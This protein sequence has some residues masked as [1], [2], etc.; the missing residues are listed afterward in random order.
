MFLASTL[1]FLFRKIVAW[2]I[3]KGVKIRYKARSE[4]W[5]WGCVKLVHSIPH[6]GSGRSS[7]VS[8]ASDKDRR[9]ACPTLGVNLQKRVL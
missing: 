5:G 6:N 4:I 3:T 9:T 8:A 1:S 7:Y 2:R